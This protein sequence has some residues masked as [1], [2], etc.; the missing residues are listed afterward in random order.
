MQNLERPLHWCGLALVAAGDP[1]HLPSRACFGVLVV[2]PVGLS[3]IFAG[4][5]LVAA[6]G[7]GAAAVA[8][9]RKARRLGAITDATLES[10]TDGILIVNPKGRIICFNRRFLQ[11]WSLGETDL[12]PGEDQRALSAV[13]D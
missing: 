13:V 7:V 2:P 9:R 4:I 3:A 8:L 12:T 1:Q 5:L 6:V 11:M 10:T